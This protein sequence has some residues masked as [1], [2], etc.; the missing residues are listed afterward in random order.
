MHAWLYLLICYGFA[1]QPAT[2]T[3]INTNSYLVVI[4]KYDWEGGVRH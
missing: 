2:N 3:N 4:P 1:K